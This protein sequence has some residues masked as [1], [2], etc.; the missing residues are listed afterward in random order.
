MKI[1]RLSEV[2]ESTIDK[3]YEELKWIWVAKGMRT[4]RDYLQF[5]S[6]LDVGPMAEGI[7]V[8]KNFFLEKRIDVFKNDVSVSG[9]ARRMLYE[10]GLKQGASFSLINGYDSD[11]HDLYK[12]N[13]TGGP[14]IVF[15]RKHKVGET[16]I[17]QDESRPCRGINGFDANSLYLYCPTLP[18]PIGRYIRRFAKEKFKPR[19]YMNRNSDMYDW[20]D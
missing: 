1:L 13:L 11:L 19:N 3:K 9:I 17:R 6:E 7:N 8:F 4:F 2:P 10:C 15:C 14:S 18:M 20:M 16:C 5:Y 12:Q